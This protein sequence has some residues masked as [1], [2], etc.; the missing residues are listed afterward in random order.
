MALSPDMIDAMLAAGLTREQMAA[1]MKVEAAKDLADAEAKR[2]AEIAAQQAKEEE[3]RA[4]QNERQQR[5][6]R[7]ASH[8]VTHQ[9]C[10]NVVDAVTRRDNPAPSLNGRPPSPTPQP[11]TLNPSP[12]P[13]SDAAASAGTA[14]PPPATELSTSDRVWVEFP[15][16]LADLSGRSDKSVRTWIGKLLAKHSA[17]EVHGALSAAV[18]AGT[19]DPFGYTVRVLNPIKP[20][21]APARGRSA[22]AADLW[23]ADAHEAHHSRQRGSDDQRPFDRSRTGTAASGDPWGYPARAA[24]H[25]G[26]DRLPAQQPGA[27]PGELPPLRLV[28]GGRADR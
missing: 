25:G 28:G 5:R 22:S 15:A 12:A 8:V 17:E 6:R 23:A 9:T 2:L 26:P 13:I 21:D 3:R 24:A 11:P 27:D 4:R 18:A 20:R 7:L 10:D 19:G 14:V 1:L 16:V